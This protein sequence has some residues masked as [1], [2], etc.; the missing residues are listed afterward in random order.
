MALPMVRRLK[1]ARPESRIVVV[2]SNPPIGEVFRRGGAV[3]EVRPMG[4]GTRGM[5]RTLRQLRR[6]KF[7]LC[8]VPFPSNR[9]QYNFFA[10]ACGARERLLHSYPVGSIRSLGLI[11]AR[12]VPAVRGIHDV[13]QNLRLLEAIGIDPGEAQPPRFEVTPEDR[14]AADVALR[15][16][17][18][19]DAM[20]PIAIHAGSARTV[21]A[22]A[23]RWP[24]E[25]YA[26]LVT[27]L[28]S[29]FGPRVLLLEGP[30]ETGVT[31]EILRRLPGAPPRV[32]R[33]SGPLGVAAA[34]LERSQ[35]YA[36]TD[37]GLAHL[38]A[39]VGTP[40][41]TLFAPADPD[42]VCPFGYRDL[43]V[44]PPGPRGENCSP[45]FEYPWKSPYPKMRCREPYCV[46]EI[47]VEQIMGA[48]R[49]AVASF[50]VARC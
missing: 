44:Q 39:A 27:A 8:L 20:L 6:E 23:K 41:V 29:E 24:P 3:D 38:A 11:P 4:R 19:P 30:D 1:E 16:V 45:C 17:N 10:R 25:S 42:R 21:L 9:W 50:C 26:K 33:L 35:L 13:V 28:E 40:A 12:R 49:R 18:W 14:A 36:G 37:S 15:G 43:V 2:A 31:D 46:R 5:I 7:G 32:L 34:V 48:V 22:A 47:S